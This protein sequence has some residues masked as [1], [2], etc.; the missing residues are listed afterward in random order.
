[1]LR[2]TITMPARPPIGDLATREVTIRLNDVA[3]VRPLP[4]DAPSFQFD[5]DVS[6]S[7]NITL[8][9]IDTS[10]NRS[11]PSSALAFVSKDE[12]PPP[13][14]GQLAVGFVEQIS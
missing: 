5:V 14:P 4:P 11:A 1:M 13:V 2:Y 10:G 8:V 6:V 12:I 9:D 7:V 3:E